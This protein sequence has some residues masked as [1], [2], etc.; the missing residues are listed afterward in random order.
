[1]EKVINSYECLFIVDVTNGDEATDAT[2]NKFMSLVE[3]NAEVVDVAKWGKRRLAYPINDM[4]EG[5][6]T[7]VTFK[8]APEF[9]SELD[10]LFNIDETVM[11]SMI[12]K[13]EYD[14]AEK[15]A[16]KVVAEEAE[17]A[18]PAVEAEPADA[19]DAE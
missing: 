6:Y 8:S 2:V 12:I 3:A 15:K 1:M 18:A 4:P 7:V 17:E 19:A 9:P 5:Y 10:R 13:L 11:R 16:A 14:A